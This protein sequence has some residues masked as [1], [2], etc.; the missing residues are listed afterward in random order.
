[1]PKLISEAYQKLNKKLHQREAAFG[2]SAGAAHAAMIAKAVSATGSRSVLDYGCGKGTLKKELLRI[3]PNL[4]VREYDPARPGKTALPEP[5]DIV[6]CFDVLEHIEPEL[7]DNVLDHIQSLT[8]RCAYFLVN[9]KPASKTLADGRNAH[10][11]VKPP[12]WW[13]EKLKVRFDV[14][15][16]K[17][18]Y[19]DTEFIAFV[20]AK[21]P[22]QPAR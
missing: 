13:V 18:V 2:T 15:D 19:G 8:L 11:I 12:E 16:L 7:I 6:A 5:A 21:T 4:D 1:M 9:C 10:L 22:Q 20:R 3:T 17:P 14:G